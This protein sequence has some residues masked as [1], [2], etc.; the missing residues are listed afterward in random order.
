MVQPLNDRIPFEILWKVFELYAEMEQFPDVS[1]KLLYVCKTWSL[2]ARQCRPLWTS[3]RINTNS[4]NEVTFW[5]SCIP[6]RLNRCGNDSLIDIEFTAI[7]TEYSIG[8][9]PA[10]LSRSLIDVLIGGMGSLISRWRSVTITLQNVHIGTQW[11]DALAHPTPSLRYLQLTGL[12]GLNPILPLAPSLIE[13]VMSDCFLRLSNDLRHLSTLRLGGIVQNIDNI[14]AA[15]SSSK[16]T[17]LILDYPRYALQQLPTT[18]PVLKELSLKGECRS[19]WLR[20]LSAPRLRFLTI[21]LFND[22]C[23]VLMEN[24]HGFS[25]EQLEILGL[26][27]FVFVPFNF[28][29]A[30]LI[31]EII[32]MFIERIGNIHCFRVFNATVLR[33]LLLSFEQGIHG[34]TQQRGF[35]LEV[36]YSSGTNHIAGK[37]FSCDSAPSTEDIQSIRKFAELPLEDTWASIADSIYVSHRD[38]RP[39]QY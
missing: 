24:T 5:T 19:E 13:L 34:P 9:T 35:K 16:I 14:E 23:H 6:L 11:I 27:S 21:N 36:C 37:A 8:D 10:A 25:F 28:Q 26:D 20:T 32:R 17:T 12:T 33:I 29:E 18:L 7:Q 39:Q 31:V 38:R 30:N 2:A 22:S 3:F 1:E 4:F 15:F